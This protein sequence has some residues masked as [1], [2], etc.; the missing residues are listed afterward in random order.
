VAKRRPRFVVAWAGGEGRSR[1]GAQC[2]A[3]SARAFK[4]AHPRATTKPAGLPRQIAPLRDEVRLP[5]QSR[6]FLHRQRHC[7]L[8]IV[9]SR[10]RGNLR[11]APLGA[12]RF[13]SAL[14]QPPGCSAIASTSS[15]LGA[16]RS[17]PASAACHD[18]SSHRANR[19]SLDFPWLLVT[20]PGDPAFSPWH[21][22]PFQAQPRARSCRQPLFPR[23][24]PHAPMPVRP[25]NGF[26]A[27][28]DLAEPG[29]RSFSA[30]ASSIRTPRGFL[31]HSREKIRDPFDVRFR[32]RREKSN[33]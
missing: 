12:A 1:H 27:S 24:R 28:L 18:V 31:F 8:R 6:R 29:R 11:L 25:G 33:P 30:S 3:R 5:T 16:G 21:R 17:T 20:R 14:I 22:H 19:E 4:R 7:P 13:F 2:P 23:A 10:E 15:A 32:F 9:P 26:A